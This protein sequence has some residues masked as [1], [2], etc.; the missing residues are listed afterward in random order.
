[1]RVTTNI[2]R[3]LV[4]IFNLILFLVIQS[5]NASNHLP[6]FVDISEEAGIDFIHNSGAF[7]EKYLPET[8]GTGCAFIDY[9]NDNWQDLLL[10]NGKDWEGHPTGKLQT[11]CLYR[12]RGN[13]TFI[14][15]TAKARLDVPLY[16]M[17][18]AVADYDNDGDADF[19]ISCLGDDRLLQNLGVETFPVVT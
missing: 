13:G 3:V 8:M 5:S 6:Q 4:C 2:Y 14:D 15:V 17:G 10:V 16:G 18:V 7:G 12:N 1:M 19:Y 9:D 11:M